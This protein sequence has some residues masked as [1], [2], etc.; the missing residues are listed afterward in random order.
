MIIYRSM[1][2]LYSIHKASVGTKCIIHGHCLVGFNSLP[3]YSVQMTTK[4]MTKSK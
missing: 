2:Y 4:L 1:H 3:L